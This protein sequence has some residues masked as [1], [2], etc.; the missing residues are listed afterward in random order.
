MSSVS[1][2]VC[3]LGSADGCVGTGC[4]G[5]VSEYDGCNA[6]DSG[7]DNSEG[8]KADAAS[9]RACCLWAFAFCFLAFLAA[10]LAA[11]LAS[12]ATNCSAAAAVALPSPCTFIMHLSQ[13]RYQCM[14]QLVASCPTQ[15]WAHGS[16]QIWE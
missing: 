3:I 8:F 2:G 16:L 6:D 1:C 4:E 5:E 14:F 11:S 7:A 9:E 13:L 12:S 10:T 15:V